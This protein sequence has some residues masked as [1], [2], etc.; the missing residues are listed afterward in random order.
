M[1]EKELG[2]KSISG[3][4][5]VGTYYMQLPFPI[6]LKTKKKNI[7]DI[8]KK[9]NQFISVFWLGQILLIISLILFNLNE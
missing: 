8:Q 2:S 9:H 1:I 3:M 4:W 5:S 6:E 7:L